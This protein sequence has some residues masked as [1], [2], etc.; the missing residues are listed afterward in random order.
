MSLIHHSQVSSSMRRPGNLTKPI[1]VAMAEVLGSEAF[2]WEED[3]DWYAF[4]EY[5]ED[6]EQPEV[7]WFWLSV[8]RY[9]R[10]SNFK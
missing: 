9:Q 8:A 6:T 4:D 1:A 10:M 2:L 5:D 3:G 7:N